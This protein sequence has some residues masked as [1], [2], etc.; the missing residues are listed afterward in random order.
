MFGCDVV[1]WFCVGL[2]FQV[3]FVFPETAVDRGV[4]G[5]VFGAPAVC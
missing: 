5:L 1:L 4:F 2:L 3:I